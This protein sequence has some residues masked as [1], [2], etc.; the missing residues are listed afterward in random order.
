MLKFLKNLLGGANSETSS[1]SFETVEYKGCR[2]TPTP[3][4]GN[5]GW[6]TEAIIEKEIDGETHTHHFIRADSSHGKDDALDL[7][8]NKCKTTIDQLGDRIFN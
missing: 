3:K 1:Q 2:I 7:I 8:M 6:S 5:N 4:Q